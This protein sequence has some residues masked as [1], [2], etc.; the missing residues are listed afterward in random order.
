MTV[1]TVSSAPVSTAGLSGTQK[2]AVVLLQLGR[3][4]AAA[5]LSRL[6][7]SEIDEITAEIV[8]LEDIDPRLAYSVMEEFHAVS[9]TGPTLIARGGVAYAQE[10]LEASL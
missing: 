6:A 2:A 1:A 9:I 7:E 8:R 10:L 5:V 3:E 4:R